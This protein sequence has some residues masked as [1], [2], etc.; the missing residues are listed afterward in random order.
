[1]RRGRYGYGYK[2]NQPLSNEA[3]K[4]VLR[5]YASHGVGYGKDPTYNSAIRILAI[6]AARETRWVDGYYCPMDHF[7]CHE[8]LGDDWKRLGYVQADASEPWGPMD[9][10]DP[11]I[12]Q[13]DY[14][15][16]CDSSGRL[17]GHTTGNFML[18]DT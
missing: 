2:F 11:A 6:N 16:A 4:V 8:R 10:V 1:M 18:R 3:S 9:T 13:F 14:L 12:A 7:V 15:P 17:A 5:C